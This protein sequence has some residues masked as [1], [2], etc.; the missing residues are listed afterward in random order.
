MLRCA[1]ICFLAISKS[2]NLLMAVLCGSGISMHP[3]YSATSTHQPQ[4]STLTFAVVLNSNCRI[5][6]GLSPVA[7]ENNGWASPFLRFY[8]QILCSVAFLSA[9]PL[10]FSVIFRFGWKRAIQEWRLKLAESAH[11]GIIKQMNARR[12]G[13]AEGRKEGMMT[14]MATRGKGFGSVH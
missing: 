4:P 3:L 8:M 12:N 5:Y 1:S 14:T 6:G 11:F 10:G 2:V 9:F 13:T 7:Y